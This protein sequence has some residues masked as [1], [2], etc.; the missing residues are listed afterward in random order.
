MAYFK[1]ALLTPY[2]S[3]DKGALKDT[4]NSVYFEDV[5]TEFYPQL[6]A[7]KTTQN[8]PAF[9]SQ[10]LIEANNSELLE[11]EDRQLLALKEHQHPIEGYSFSDSKYSLTERKSSTAFSYG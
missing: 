8:H 2:S 3:V 4:Y 6:E 11:E 9:D 10:E 7:Y 5:I 1:L